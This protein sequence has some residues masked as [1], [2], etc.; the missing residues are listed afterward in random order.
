M[1][2]YRISFSSLTR[3]DSFSDAVSV[4][5]YRCSSLSHV[6]SKTRLLILWYFAGNVCVC[7]CLPFFLVSYNFFCFYMLWHIVEIELLAL[8]SMILCVI[9][10]LIYVNGQW[11]LYGI[12]MYH[13]LIATVVTN[14][15]IISSNWCVEDCCAPWHNDHQKWYKNDKNW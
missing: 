11:M 7:V 8:D 4:F 9:K 5:F 6:Y 15:T 10:C 12:N 3:L 14:V 2:T 13:R 1:H